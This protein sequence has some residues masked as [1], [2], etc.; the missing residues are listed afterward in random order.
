MHPFRS[1][2]LP[3]LVVS[4][5]S[6]P[7]FSQSP[8]AQ[9]DAVFSEWDRASS[10]GCAVGVI[11]DGELIY[12]RGYGM[13][14]LEHNIPITSTS[15]F[16]IGSTSKQFTAM[17]L[18]LLAEQGSLSLDDDIRD[19]ISELPQYE[20]PVTIRQMLNH[21]S[22][23]RDYLQVMSLAGMRSDDFYTD[24]DVLRMLSQSETLNFPP[25]DQFLYS[26][27]G[28]FLVSQIV[29]RVTGTSLREFAHENIFEPLGM[30]DTHF[31]DDHRMVV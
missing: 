27:S 5:A 6:V 16:R 21:T 17:A 22:G 8:N 28:Y 2:M 30:D 31:H 14:N 1:V 25:G 29:R 20:A 13:A 15:V 10:P 24:G 3:I 11:R 19:Y 4:L 18:L 7:C 9:V 23:I 26:N 12:E